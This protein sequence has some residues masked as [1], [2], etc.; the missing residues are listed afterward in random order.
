MQIVRKDVID[1]PFWRNLP[2]SGG[3]TG[4]PRMPVTIAQESQ[5]S[6]LPCQCGNLFR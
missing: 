2:R 3:L 1:R 5:K 4:S 6:K